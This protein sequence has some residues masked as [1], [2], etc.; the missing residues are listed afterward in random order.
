MMNF[1]DALAGYNVYHYTS[2]NMSL[3][4]HFLHKVFHHK[5]AVVISFLCWAV[6]I[7]LLEQVW[8]SNIVKYKNTSSTDNME[9]TEI[10]YDNGFLQY[11]HDGPRMIGNTHDVHI[12]IICALT[13]RGLPNISMA[14]IEYTFP[15]YKSLLPSFCATASE[16]SRYHY[17]FLHF[18]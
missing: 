2:S 6:A 11:F 9:E 13:T 7:Y 3:E 14:H 8:I 4:E 18:A 10:I 17:H 1:S 5:R 12:A 16:S 15:F